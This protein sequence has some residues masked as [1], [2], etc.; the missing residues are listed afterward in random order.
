MSNRNRKFESIIQSWKE[1]N[2]RGSSTKRS[3]VNLSYWLQSGRKLS[4]NG[5]A[6]R[7]PVTQEEQ[8][9]VST[10][11]REKIYEYSRD[12]YHDMHCQGTENE[13][14]TPRSLIIRRINLSG[15]NNDNTDMHGPKSTVEDV[16]GFFI[17]SP[18]V[19][20][21]CRKRERYVLKMSVKVV[22][23]RTTY[24]QRTIK[25]GMVRMVTIFFVF[26]GRAMIYLAG[27]MDFSTNDSPLS[28]F[29]FGYVGFRRTNSH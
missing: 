28:I 23:Y 21:S 18:T 17:N 1:S 2:P 26:L 10:K 9:E 22:Q 12:P 11:S 19:P 14:N 20:D 5:T 24:Y 29:L 4:E 3:N 13:I 25:Y 15:G 8:I 7:S 16:F 6:H 27:M